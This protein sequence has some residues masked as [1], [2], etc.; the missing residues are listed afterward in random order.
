M[1]QIDRQDIINIL[2]CF[3]L[4]N[5]AMTEK[6]IYEMSIDIFVKTYE[7]FIKTLEKINRK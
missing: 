1:Y 5:L 4:N 3:W 7:K 6:M 2:T